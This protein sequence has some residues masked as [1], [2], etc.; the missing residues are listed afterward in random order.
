[1]PVFARAPGVVVAVAPATLACVPVPVPAPVPAVVGVVPGVP[2]FVVGGAVVGTVVAGGPLVVV[3]TAVTTIVPCMK[4]CT[5]Q[6]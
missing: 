5:R 4:L 1:M 3:V 2:G 6:W